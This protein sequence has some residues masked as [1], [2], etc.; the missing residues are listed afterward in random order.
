MNRVRYKQRW[1]R[2]SWICAECKDGRSDTGWQYY[3]RRD[4]RVLAVPHP[5]ACSLSI[6]GPQ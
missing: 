3:E 1:G 6:R 4:S 2:S 5:G